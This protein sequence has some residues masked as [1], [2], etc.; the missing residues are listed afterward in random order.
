MAVDIHPLSALMKRK[1]REVLVENLL[2]TKG[3][4]TLV[5]PSGEGKTTTG[6]SIV[7]LVAAGGTWAGK[8]ID[9][10]PVLWI[11]GEGEDD[12]PPMVQAGAKHHGLDWEKLPISICFE[13]VEFSLRGETDKLIEKL[14]G[15]P[16]MLII[17]DALADIM[18]ELDED[19][20]KHITQVYTN[21]RRVEKATGSVILVLH[22]QGWNNDRERGSTA[23]RAKSDIVVQIVE[24]KPDQGYVKFAH[25]KRRGGPR[26]K[27]FVYE[28]KLVP[29]EGCEHDV[30]IVTGVDATVSMLLNQ[31]LAADEEH[32]RDLVQIMVAQPKLPIRFKELEKRS[33]K[34]NS[35]F[36]RGLNE[37]LEG[38]G[39]LIKGKGGYALNSDR[40]WE[41]ALVVQD[42][43]QV[44]GP[45]VHPYRG[46]DPLDPRGTGPM[47]PAGPKVDPGPKVG[48]EPPIPPVVNE[49]ELEKAAAL[50]RKVVP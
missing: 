4:T 36:K 29:V 39:W 28:V 9:P 46:V 48:E 26:L 20:A 16:P 41:A 49:V 30:P 37:A 7:L 2:F 45:K 21:L 44:Q 34:T 42:Q 47:D 14:K 33:G 17:V 23:I 19:K 18:G 27:E 11:A 38:K 50:L 15:M 32:A 1:P 22:H 35:T 6:L 10:R 12:L 31:D 8:K 25:L 24:F 3:I 40:S 13:A 43:G 5:A